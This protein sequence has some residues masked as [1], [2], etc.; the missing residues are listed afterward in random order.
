MPG[1]DSGRP[2]HRPLGDCQCRN[3]HRRGALGLKRIREPKFSSRI[4]PIRSWSS[5]LPPPSTKYAQEGD[6]LEGAG[7]RPKE[8]AMKVRVREASSNWQRLV[9]LRIWTCRSHARVP[10]PKFG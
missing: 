2:G 4:W 5:W 9:T 10:Q 7:G 8:I 6:R 3:D 1:D